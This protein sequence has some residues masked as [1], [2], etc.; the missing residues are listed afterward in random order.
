MRLDLWLLLQPEASV[1][2]KAAEKIIMIAMCFIF[3]PLFFPN[4]LE[5]HHLADLS[6]GEGQLPESGLV[7]KVD[8]PDPV[9]VACG[10]SGVAVSIQPDSY[11]VECRVGEDTRVE[12]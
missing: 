8:N 4:L 11:S 7:R 5:C 10:A 9:V 6:N 3:S 1:K 12:L 2:P